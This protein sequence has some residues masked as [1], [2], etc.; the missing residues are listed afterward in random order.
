MAFNQ[1]APSAPAVPFKSTSAVGNYYQAFLTEHAVPNNKGFLVV[2]RQPSNLAAASAADAE[3]I[4][5]DW[6][7]GPLKISFRLN[8]KS[9]Y[10]EAAVSIN[11]WP[12]GSIDLVSLKGDLNKGVSASFN[13]AV[14]SGSVT[15]F[16]RGSSLWVRLNI[17]SVVGDWNEEFEIFTIPFFQASAVAAQGNGV[18]IQGIAAP[19]GLDPVQYQKFLDFQNFVNK[20]GQTG[21]SQSLI[22]AN[23]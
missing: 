8:L 11:V 20:G 16:I 13:V 23:A 15:L 17:S 18:G 14:A 3:P 1:A 10:V 2:H 9:L 7:W 19:G 6:G 12:F 4:V 5:F 21:G 22:S